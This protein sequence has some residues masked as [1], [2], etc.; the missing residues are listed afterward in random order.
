MTA[1]ALA[2]AR[3][4]ELAFELAA[5]SM[6]GVPV[7]NRTLS[8]EVV[9]SKWELRATASNAGWTGYSKR[10]TRWFGWR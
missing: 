1:D 9:G 4:V 6:A 8:I 5:P 3:D 2:R 7:C 10:S